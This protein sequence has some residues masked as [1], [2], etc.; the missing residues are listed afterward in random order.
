M[1]PL[2]AHTPLCGFSSLIV[3]S[4][5]LF[6]TKWVSSQ[7]KYKYFS[8]IKSKLGKVRKENPENRILKNVIK[9]YEF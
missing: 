7:H 9:W 2:L 1:T 6:I 3:D 4:Y 5:F 8:K